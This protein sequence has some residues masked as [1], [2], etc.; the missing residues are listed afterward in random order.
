MFKRQFNQMPNVIKSPGSDSDSVS[1]FLLEKV[2][3][4]ILFFLLQ[5]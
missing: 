3:T 2:K 4:F 5:G 1:I